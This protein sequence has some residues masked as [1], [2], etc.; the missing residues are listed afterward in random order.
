MDIFR[1]V[2][3]FFINKDYSFTSKFIGLLSFVIILLLIDNTLGLSFYYSNNQKLNQI[4]T[5]ELL[6]RDCKNN[7]AIIRVLENTEQEVL[8]RKNV[9]QIFLNLFSSEPLISTGKSNVDT[10]NSIK[11]L[12][13][14]NLDG[15]IDSCKRRVDSLTYL[16]LLQLDIFRICG[17]K[18]DDSVSIEER[19]AIRTILCDDSNNH[20][21]VVRVRSKLWHTLSSSYIL[22]LFLII[23]PI[24]LLSKNK[25]NRSILFVI[26]IFMLIDAILI[27]LNQYLFGLIPLILNKPLINY[28]LNVVIHTSVCML[29]GFVVSK[30]NKDTTKQ[31]A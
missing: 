25:I 11:L 4:K 7:D 3:R 1:E 29:I 18:Y 6:K 5:I 21:E 13:R 2:F 8:N 24:V 10:V 14:G 15:K 20:I 23:L 22:I 31:A 26:I 9:F 17:S 12:V 28:L 19:G 30:M 27:W 16:K